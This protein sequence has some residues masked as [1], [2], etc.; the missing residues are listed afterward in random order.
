MNK[1]LNI[2]LIVVLISAAPACFTDVKHIDVKH[3]D[4][5]GKQ[6][7]APVSDIDIPKYNMAEVCINNVVYYKEYYRIAPKVILRDRVGKGKAFTGEEC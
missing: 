7:K 2:L 4:N 5:T 3:I 6:V 1:I